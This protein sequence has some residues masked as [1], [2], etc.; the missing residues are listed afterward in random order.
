M[1]PPSSSSKVSLIDKDLLSFKKHIRAKHESLAFY[2]HCSQAFPW[3]FLWVTNLHSMSEQKFRPGVLSFCCVVIVQW[4][5]IQQYQ[6]KVWSIFLCFVILDVECFKWH[7]N[8]NVV[9]HGG[10]AQKVKF[11][12]P[13][14]PEAA[15]EK[16]ILD[17]CPACTWVMGSRKW[18]YPRSGSME[19]QYCNSKRKIGSNTWELQSYR[20]TE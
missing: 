14:G 17:W 7:S 2:S 10:R 15:F 3:V 18:G 5:L 11:S 1:S 6:S 8:R 4:T 13:P 16:R 20:A 12:S 9:S 19:Q